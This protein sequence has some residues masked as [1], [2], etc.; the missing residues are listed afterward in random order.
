MTIFSVAPL[1]PLTPSAPVSRADQAAEALARIAVIQ[2]V[3]TLGA[4]IDQSQ[5]QPQGDLAHLAKDAVGEGE[6]GRVKA[7]EARAVAAGPEAQVE[8]PARAVAVAAGRAAARQAGLAPLMADMVQAAAEPDTPRQV[9]A[10]IAQVM[11]LGARMDGQIS[12]PEIRQALQRSGLFLEARLA[13][14]AD[15]L[16]PRPQTGT[17]TAPP[18]VVPTP[19]PNSDLKAA[20]LVFREV[21]KSW[22]DALPPMA[23]QAGPTLNATAGA[24]TP[25]PAATA[26]ASSAQLVDHG[27]SRPL[28]AAASSTP[29]PAG[30]SSNPMAVD[31]E[32]PPLAAVPTR[33]AGSPIARPPGGWPNVN[34]PSQAARPA[35]A[36]QP[37]PLPAFGAIVA[38]DF[39]AMP[40]A[41]PRAAS[42][43]VM[44]YGGPEVAPGPP[45]QTPPP[46]AGA[47]THAQAAAQPGRPA[48]AGPHA[49][50]QRLL[51]ETGA[52][53]A[54]TELLQIASLPEPSV[55]GRPVEE[56]GQRWVFDMPFMTPQ[57][58]A[59]AQF[60]ISRDIYRDGGG[61]GGEGGRGLGR[62]WR[63]RFSLDVEPMGPVHAQ[64]ALTGDR[65]RVSLWAERPAAMARLRVGEE[66]LGSALREAALEPEIAFH[67]G[68]PRAP[69]AAPGQ[70]LD[71]AT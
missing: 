46:Y 68:Q 60:E 51:A 52:A 48:G 54:R 38:D 43:A 62:T 4:M 40:L 42:A 7:A 41:A 65:A 31:P 67:A 39:P 8:T 35:P 16:P 36:P 25:G 11:A 55:A 50:A 64:V 30:P 12:G 44:A 24:A 45:A 6:A 33:D 2:T 71:Q 14:V 1:S 18:R 21:V 22:A 32:G 13:T 49:V 15:G 19:T 34:A 58:P 66:R 3:E 29:S 47:P 27:A 61:S 63:A 5:S 56:H 23:A 53:L 69:A 59:A 37:P 26:A 9:K 10:A 20:L 70:F 57:G 28:T 17:L